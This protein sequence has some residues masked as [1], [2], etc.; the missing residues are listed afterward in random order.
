MKADYKNWVPI[1]G[2]FVR[3]NE[4]ALMILSDLMLL[5]EESKEQNHS[6]ALLQDHPL[7]FS[8]FR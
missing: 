8:L 7:W 3:T 2:N 6:D 1:D 5:A 4:P